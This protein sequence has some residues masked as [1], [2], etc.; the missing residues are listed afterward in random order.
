MYFNELHVVS[1]SPRRQAQ[2][3]RGESPHPTIMNFSSP[4]K[5]LHRKQDSGMISYINCI[6][7]IQLRHAFFLKYRKIPR[8]YSWPRPQRIQNMFDAFSLSCHALV[9]AGPDMNLYVFLMLDWAKSPVMTTVSW[10]LQPAGH[11][12]IGSVSISGSCESV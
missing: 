7:N 3:R 11:L 8:K 1:Y 2:S 6:Q 4:Q 9:N 10:T 5:A 12:N